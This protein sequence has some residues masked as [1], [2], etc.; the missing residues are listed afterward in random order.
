MPG[1]GRMSTHAGAHLWRQRKVHGGDRERR[2]YATCLR[3]GEVRPKMAARAATS[4]GGVCGSLPIP[5]QRVSRPPARMA[6]PVAASHGS[7]WAGR[8]P[9]LSPVSGHGG[10]VQ[11]SRR[12]GK[13]TRAVGVLAGIGRRRRNRLGETRSTAAWGEGGAAGATKDVRP[14]RI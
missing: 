8:R 6:A 9:P 11:K 5:R 1:R 13:K 12:A 10:H 3:W 7:V 14:G 4:Y 2:Y